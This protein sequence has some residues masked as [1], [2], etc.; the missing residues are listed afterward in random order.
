MS[1]LTDVDP[2]LGCL[3]DASIGVVGYGSQG[4]AQALNLAESGLDVCVGVREDG[5]SWKRAIDDGMQVARIPEAVAASDVV[6]FLVPDEVHQEV[7]EQHVEP[8][9]RSGD[10]LV[11][12]H[13]F[14]LWSEQIQPPEDVDVGLL[15]PK[16][17]GA[18]VREAYEEGAGVPALVAVH[19]DATQTAGD[20]LLALAEGIGSTRAGLVETTVEE[21]TVT[22][23]FGEQAVLCGGLAGLVRAG[24]ETLVEAGYTAEVAYFEVV[25]ELKLIV[26]MLQ[27]GGLEHMWANVSNT[28]EYG[29]RT[30]ADV[31]VGEDVRSAM[32]DVLGEIEGQTFT[33]EWIEESQNGS[34]TLQRLRREGSQAHIEAVCEKM[35]DG[36]GWDGRK[37]P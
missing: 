13:G 36:V 32:Q 22:D 5:P 24:F 26:D 14:T 11:L 12:A 1:M 16:A 7:F 35:S 28:A 19:Q 17:P 31:I 6:V 4:R 8:H 30:R 27:R 37:H 23:L 18:M 34:R 20:R 3:E 10:L 29:G 15:A 21:E 9:L 33:R 2:R 25:N